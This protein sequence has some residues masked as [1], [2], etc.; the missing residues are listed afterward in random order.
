MA[1]YLIGDIHGCYAELQALLTQVAFNPTHDQLYLTGDL[2]A[3]GPD[4]LAVLRFLYQHRQAVYP[5]LGNHDL[6]LLALYQGIGT[7]KSKDKLDS[8]LADKQ[9]D[10]YMD[11]LRHQ[12][13][14]RV[15]QQK[16]LILCHAGYYPLWDLATATACAREVEQ[17]LQKDDYR[18]FLLKMHGNLPS[19]WSNQL[20]GHPRWRFIINAFTRMRYCLPNGQLDM[21]CKLPPD[22]VEK[23]LQPWFTLPLPYD[24]RPFSIVFGHW[25]SLAGYP[26]P[27]T[28]YPLDT[29]CCWGGALTCLRWEDK[30]V[31]SQAALSS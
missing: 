8:L 23:P 24:L 7:S 22:Q 26:T 12:P 6:H 2:I 31:F 21:Y 25:A 29:G 5:V 11:Y 1:T 16:Q 3:R 15:D 20:T 14:L 28:I 27:D 10:Q 30:Q 18:L 4:S 19:L 13:L 17:Q 9:I